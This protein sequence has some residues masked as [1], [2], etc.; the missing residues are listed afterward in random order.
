MILSAPLLPL[1]SLTRQVVEAVNKGLAINMVGLGAALVGIAALVGNL[2]AKTLT[3][4]GVGPWAG[5]AGA[6]GYN[7]V[8][9]LDVFLV[10]VGAG[11]GGGLRGSTTRSGAW[12]GLRGVVLACAASPRVDAAS[13]S[14][15]RRFDRVAPSRISPPPLTAGR[16]QLPA[17][18]LFEP[19]VRP[20]AA[21]R[22]RR[23]RRLAHTGEP[24]VRAGGMRRFLLVEGRG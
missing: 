14:R 18:A 2:A 3:N 10:Q 11:W 16:R 17:G 24:F 12:R 9:A 6:A 15:G 23:G 19:R 4:A 1:L 8:V 13:K 20:L 21:G 7:P 5:A 22:G